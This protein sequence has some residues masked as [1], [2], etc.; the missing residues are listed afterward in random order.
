MP[1][2]DPFDDAPDKRDTLRI[3]V[4]IPV[5][6]E[7]MGERGTGLMS[8]VGARIHVT[9]RVVRRLRS[10]FGVHFESVDNRLFELLE[11]SIRRLGPLSDDLED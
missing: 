8:D 1:P 3:P 11:I 7:H 5:E 4:G 10:G 9:G 6:L 2:E